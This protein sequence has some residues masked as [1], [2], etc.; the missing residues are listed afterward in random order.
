MDEKFNLDSIDK[1]FTQFKAGAKIEGEV[2]AFLKE[3][4][5]INIGGKKD[6]IIKYGDEED[7]A[8]E[9][10]KV[11]DK[12][13]V[14]ITATKDESG[15][16]VLSKAKAD[17]LRKGNQEVNNLK[18]GE[19]SS[20]IITGFNKAGIISKLGDFEVFIPYSQISSRKVDNNLQNYV[21][22]QVNAIVLEIDLSN[23]KIIASIKAFEENEQH[24][25]ETA[26]WQAIFENK[27][28]S[29]SVVRFV[30][31]G[32]FVNIDGVD[33]LVHNNEVSYDK[34]KKASE[35]L[36]L[37]KI[38]NFK[39]IK[40]DRENKKISLSYKALQVNPLTEKIKK[41]RVGDVVNGVVTKILPFGALIKFGDDIEG[42]LHVKEAS[43]FYVK[44]VYEVAKVGKSLDLKIIAIDLENNKVSLSLKAMQEE[45]EVVK[46]ANDISS[47]NN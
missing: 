46:L 2:V 29:G 23:N 22:K 12:F 40:C 45:P 47:E 33:C 28:V 42:L 8:I 5:L 26:F 10:V 24:T 27:I 19:T 17:A 13:E 36:E 16:V 25:K 41:L 4:L 18:V 7:A 14:I 9:N 21:N 35:V 3:G 32:A 39:V 6:G 15:A 20:F 30:D 37:G 1:T 11:G 31:F 34:L 38:Y 44:N 43:H